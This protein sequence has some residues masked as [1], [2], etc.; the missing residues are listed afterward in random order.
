MPSIN[1]QRDRQRNGERGSIIIMAAIFMGLL[2][3]MLGFA[4]DASRIYMVRA[5][6]QNAADASALAAAR[7]LNSGTTGIDA[8]VAQANNVIARN[9]QGFG[10]RVVSIASIQFA[11]TLTEVNNVDTTNWLSAD[12]AKLPAN[13]EQI[14]F[15][16]VTTQP[17]TI[18]ILFGISALGSTRDETRKAVAGMSVGLNGICDYFN[19][20]VA[21][22]E[23][24][25]DTGTLKYSFP[26]GVPLRLNFVS[27]DTANTI[28]LH[29]MD[30]VVLDTR[31]ATGTGA[32]ETVDATAGVNPR[33][34]QL[35]EVIDFEDAN[36]SNDPKHV[37]DGTN[38]RFDIYPGGIKYPDVRPDLNIYGVDFSPITLLQYQGGS[39]ASGP[40]G[41]HPGQSA[42]RMLL[43]PVVN[44][45]ETPGVPRGQVKAFRAFFLK[46][47]VD[48]E[49]KTKSK[50]CPP[51]AINNGD[52]IVEYAGD[53]YVV[54]R[55]VYDPSSCLTTNV[56]V[57]VLY[58]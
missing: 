40:A 42:R 29:N 28:T 41:N 25:E 34:R 20:A 24:N 31:W 56:T 46:Q 47:T 1:G 26:V 44:P 8:A 15:V 19:I 7:E 58:K 52:L 57:A 35:G 10:K 37:A 51:N 53:N 39:P 45:I 22:K 9:T 4:I 36:S 49:C 17:T 13:V 55:G 2:F 11:L 54:G 3:L 6:L 27:S 30:Y 48:G 16:R 32:R 43:V 50:P 23:I 12:D 21:R 38:T 14:K 18:N 33:C 5:E